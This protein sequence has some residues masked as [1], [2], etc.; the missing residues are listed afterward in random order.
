MAGARSYETIPSNLTQIN[1]TTEENK[2]AERAMGGQT[3]EYN[4]FIN[5]FSFAIYAKRAKSDVTSDVSTR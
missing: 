3:Y 2:H 5:H 1:L 4:K